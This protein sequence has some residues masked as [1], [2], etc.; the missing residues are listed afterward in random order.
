MSASA[1]ITTPF[2]RSAAI[3]LSGGRLWRKKLLPVGSIVY[4]GPGAPPEGRRIH[5]TADY[6]AGLAEAFRDKAYD[7]VPFQLAGADNK[8]TNDVERFRGEILDMDLAGDGLYVTCRT[9]DAG[10]KILSENPGLGV[11][12]RISEGYQRSDGKYFP[13]AI[14]HVLGTLDPHV[15]ALGPW[16]SAD[17]ANSGGGLVIDLSSWEYDGAAGGG[18]SDADLDAVLGRVG[19][20]E[21]AGLIGGDDWDDT[22]LAEIEAIMAE[23]D[24]IGAEDEAAWGISDEQWA[25]ATMEEL[26]LIGMSEQVAG[27]AVRAGDFAT[28]AAVRLDLSGHRPGSESGAI[29]LASSR[30]ASGQF[31]RACGPLDDFG[32]C[33]ERYHQAGCGAVTDSAAA[34]GSAEQVAGWRDSIA[35]RHTAM[36]INGGVTYA[37]AG[38]G[39]PWTMRDAVYASLGIT[40]RTSPFETGAGRG[41]VPTPAR[42]IAYGDPD[43]PDSGKGLLHGDDGLAA[44]LGLAGA[45]AED[46]RRTGADRLA[47]QAFRHGTARPNL[48]GSP[49]EGS[50][51]YA[52]T[53]APY[54]PAGDGILGSQVAL[55]NVRNAGGG[56]Y[57]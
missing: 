22:E 55:S 4:R 31:A 37:D 24:A 49:L 13:A 19:R 43:D 48:Q 40:P 28:A 1:S 50:R 5:F 30:A 21:E 44:R 41:E 14:Q 8:H 26:A 53:P 23:A 47:T 56:L 7:Q 20:L 33:A 57:D 18:L 17:L 25:E 12:A 42:V 10:E 27:A 11:S 29:E 3:E 9:T 35:Q 46:A 32:R 45:T 51:T 34:S 16:Q 2:A 54:G 52:G 15:P 6:L 38:T 39:E 36:V